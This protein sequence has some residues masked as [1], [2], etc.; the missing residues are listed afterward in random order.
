MSLSVIFMKLLFPRLRSGNSLKSVLGDFQGSY[1]IGDRDVFFLI[2]LMETLDKFMLDQMLIHKFFSP[3]DDG[4][5]DAGIPK[6]VIANKWLEFRH[7]PLDLPHDLFPDF[8]GD[9]FHTLKIALVMD[10][11]LNQHRYFFVG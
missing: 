1:R 6:S 7:S 8:A 4:K 5:I 11:N 9:P 10:A 3:Q 2:T